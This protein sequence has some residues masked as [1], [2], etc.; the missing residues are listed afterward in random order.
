MESCV[1]GVLL[2][3]DVMGLLK[4]GTYGVAEMS[5]IVDCLS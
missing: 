1:G 4:E 3:D 5:F 2:D